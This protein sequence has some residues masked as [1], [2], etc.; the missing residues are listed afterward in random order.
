MKWHTG[1][2]AGV[3]QPKHVSGFASIFESVKKLDSSLLHVDR[4]RIL[5]QPRRAAN[6]VAGLSKSTTSI[7]LLQLCL[8]ADAKKHSPQKKRLYLPAQFYKCNDCTTLSSTRGA[9]CCICSPENRPYTNHRFL[10]GPY[11]LS[12][13]DLVNQ[14]A[15]VSLQDPIE[16]PVNLSTGKGFVKDN[17]TFMV[18]DKLDIMPSTTI[19]SMSV[20]H[21]LNVASLADLESNKVAVTITQVIGKLVYSQIS[22][23]FLH[24][25]FQFS[26]ASASSMYFER[27]SAEIL[28]LI[29]TPPSQ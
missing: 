13:E 10:E 26:L 27:Q 14:E 7:G 8:D 17:I 5:A 24:C 11:F 9:R 18:T 4:N 29:V 19:T 3:P 1:I 12:A 2:F 25:N 23:F 20:L 21:T 16:E 6:D 15:I 28:E 22:L